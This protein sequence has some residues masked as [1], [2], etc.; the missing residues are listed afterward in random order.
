MREGRVKGI[1]RELFFGIGDFTRTYAR[2]CDTCVFVLIFLVV[3]DGSLE[4][5]C[6][7]CYYWFVSGLVTVWIYKWISKWKKRKINI[8]FIATNIKFIFQLLGV[9]I[10]ARDFLCVSRKCHNHVLRLLP[11]QIIFHQARNAIEWGCCLF[12]FLYCEWNI[13]WQV[14]HGE[15]IMIIGDKMSWSFPCVIRNAFDSET[16]LWVINIFHIEKK[17][18]IL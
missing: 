18:N 17:N 4:T 15:L 3:S 9:Q 5:T 10:T 14:R 2:S 11:Q 13:H 16:G 8:T 7:K 1:S 6:T 12:F